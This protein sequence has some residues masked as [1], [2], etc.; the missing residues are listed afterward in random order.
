MLA[1]IPR[2]GT[3]GL[4]L[5]FLRAGRFTVTRD[6]ALAKPPPRPK[7]KVDGLD[8]FGRDVAQVVMQRTFIHT[9]LAVSFCDSCT[10]VKQTSN[11]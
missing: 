10:A 8:R 7:I 9:F 5:R 11:Y 4:G 6:C 3:G 1:G 2:I